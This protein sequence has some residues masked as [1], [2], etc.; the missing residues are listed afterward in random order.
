MWDSDLFGAT[1]RIAPWVQMVGEYMERAQ[2]A[3]AAGKAP[4]SS[5]V[6]QYATGAILADTLLHSGWLERIR[7]AE[8]PEAARDVL[9]RALLDQPR[10]PSLETLGRRLRE[11][12]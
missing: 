2:E 6:Q 5:T 12:R 7:Q 3:Q 10:I 4:P 11:A 1:V 8:T 9:L